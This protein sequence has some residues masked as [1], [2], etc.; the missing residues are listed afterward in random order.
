M[1]RDSLV[2]KGHFNWDGP[3]GPT[4]INHYIMNKAWN[5]S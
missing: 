1:K 2:V 3:V 4:K 5:K